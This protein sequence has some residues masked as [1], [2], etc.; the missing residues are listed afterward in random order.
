LS[1]SIATVL[2]EAVRGSRAGFEWTTSVK[3]VRGR[4]HGAGEK[5]YGADLAIEI[6]IKQR[7]G[8]V[9]RKTLLVQSKKEW[10]ATDAKLRDQAQK[11]ALLPGSGVVVDYRPDGYRAVSVDAAANAD[12]DARK[13]ADNEFRD[14][15]DVLGS[16]FLEC[17]IGSTNIYYDVDEDIIVVVDS[18]AEGRPTVRTV[19]FAAN[20]RVRTDI[21]TRVPKPKQAPRRK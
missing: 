3:K 4:G 10:D 11:I 21:R 13:V 15:G 17:K 7:D 8:A 9:R 2:R 16:D 12:G 20:Y 14:F 19:E 18:D 5:R 1:G 6:Q